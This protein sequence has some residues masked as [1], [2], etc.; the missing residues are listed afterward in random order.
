[1]HRSRPGRRSLLLF[2]LCSSLGGGGEA[3]GHDTLS[4]SIFLNLFSF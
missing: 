3:E 1:M 4:F 2:E